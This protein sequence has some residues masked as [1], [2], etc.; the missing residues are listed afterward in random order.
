MVISAYGPKGV[1]LLKVPYPNIS[2]K[3]PAMSNIPPIIP[4]FL[5]MSS[6]IKHNSTFTQGNCAIEHAT[7]PSDTTSKDVVEGGGDADNNTTGGGVIER[8]VLY[9]DH[10]EN[11]VIYN[12]N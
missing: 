6:R 3:M 8:I 1:Y 11:L 2:K 9:I 5:G 4:I 12:C 7:H 10:Q